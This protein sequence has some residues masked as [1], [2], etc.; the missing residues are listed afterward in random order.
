MKQAFL[1]DTADTFQTYIYENNRKIVPTSAALTV[2][3]PGSDVKLVDAASM[4]VGASGL[5]SYSLTAAQSDTADENY[6]AVVSYV[7]NAVTYTLTLFYDVVHSKLVKVVTDEDVVSE[8]PQ[9]KDNGWRVHGTA[10]SGSS[11]TLVDTELQRYDDDYFT[12]GLAYSIDKDETREV[13]DFVSST[14][15]VTTEPFSSAISTDKYVL[16]R[17]FSKEIQRGFEKIEEAL[18]R[19]GKRP[20]LVL[21]PYDLREVHIY[22]SVAEACKGLVAGH[23]EF[24]WQ[25]WKDYEKK[26]EDTFS[27]INFKYDSS[28]DGYVIGSEES[29]RVSVA[30]AGRR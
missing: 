9:L 4:N 30:R 24:W 13:T 1:I 2:Y 27:G 26:A 16:T 10:E 21:D 6:K 23:G 28:G 20:H 25:M 14:G 22:F 11:T 29:S 12:G 19:R 15:T 5:L 3:K 7:Y 18:V 8:L 17:S